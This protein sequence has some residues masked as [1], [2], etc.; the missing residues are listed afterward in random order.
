MPRGCRSSSG[1]RA[2]SSRRAA[3]APR[4]PALRATSTL[5]LERRGD[6]LL[7]A[8]SL[9]RETTR[10]ALQLLLLR[11]GPSGIEA[12]TRTVPLDAPR[13]TTT[14][15]A[16]GLYALRAAVGWL[17]GARFVPLTW[18]PAEGP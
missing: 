14:I 7:F 1:S 15:E 13:G 12:E 5:T 6:A 11:R 16:P 2:A 8:W 10:P 18:L 9:P 17:D 3:P 4:R